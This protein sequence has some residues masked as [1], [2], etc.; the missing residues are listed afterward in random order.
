MTLGPIAYRT[1]PGWLT[2]AE[3][4]CLYDV[5]RKTTGGVFEAGTF[6]GRS[7]SA[8]CEGLRDSMHRDRKFISYD[9]ATGSEKEFL[10]FMRSL[11][12]CTDDV[13][14]PKQLEETWAAGSN[15]TIEA[16]KHLALTGLDKFVDLRIGDFRQDTGSYS[17]LFFDVTHGPEEIDANIDHMIRLANPK[18]IITMHDM[19]MD[20]TLKYVIDKTRGRLN[21]FRLVDSLALFQK[22]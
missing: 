11:G 7:T 22:L 16:R 13:H 2:D 10:A 3:A 4:F 8:L 20:G 6:Y 1:I 15:S 12:Y 21:F 17:A 19:Y 14:L 18:G 9:L 5:A